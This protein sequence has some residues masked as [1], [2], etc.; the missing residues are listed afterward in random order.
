[1]V[2]EKN[3]AFNGASVSNETELRYRAD[4]RG[5]MDTAAYKRAVHSF[6]VLK[7]ISGAFQER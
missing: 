1:M 3:S 2:G 6:L 4:K 5:S 7:Y